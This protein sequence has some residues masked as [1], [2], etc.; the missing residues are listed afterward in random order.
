MLESALMKFF[1][2][3]LS[4]SIFLMSFA[5]ASFSS[6]IHIAVLEDSSLIG[7][8]PFASRVRIFAPSSLENEEESQEHGV[9]V[10]SVLVGKNSPLPADTSITLVPSLQQ[11]SSYIDTQEPK[12][13]VIL[14]WSGCAGYPGLSEEVLAG[15]ETISAHFKTIL[16][17][18]L[19]QFTVEVHDYIAAYDDMLAQL[20]SDDNPLSVILNHT[21]T[22][23]LQAK[24]QPE[25]IAERKG[26][27]V[28]GVAEKIENF[29]NHAE[30]RA[31]LKFQE[32]KEDLL[33]SLNRH[34]NTLI[35]WALGNEGECIDAD[36]FWQGLLSDE[37]ILSHTL[38]VY[39]VQ[40][41]GQ[42]NANS[43]F[44]RLYQEHALGK[45]Y[46]SQVWNAE[47]S[48]YVQDSGTSFSAPLATIDAF[49]KAKDI[50][51]RTGQTP[52]YADV[53]RALLV[54]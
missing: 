33:K 48:R 44:T 17:K 9:A 34:D 25:R 11:F 29:K 16:E 28:S 13:L 21:K 2:F 10:C 27:Y 23:L 51:D 54:K 4:H 45:P 5:S 41:H 1:K 15:L 39:G 36:P 53:K 31:K 42:K 26:S 19:T 37:I 12:D 40:G 20:P 24:E 52:F 3:F 35:V 46:N 7:E 30:E 18:D 14:N 50:L 32:M 47:K 49:T 22:C 43:N 8:A 38:L 6:P